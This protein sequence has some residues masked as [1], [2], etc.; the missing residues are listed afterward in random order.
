MIKS[1]ICIIGAG[2]AGNK[3]LNTLMDIDDTYVPVFCN[4]NINEMEE[5]SHFNPDTNSLYINSA[6]GTG[7]NR[8]KAKE[9][10]E[11]SGSRIISFFANKF[12][13]SSGIKTF[14]IL[15]SADGGTGSGAVPMLAQAI[16]AVN[17]EAS[18]NLV[19]AFPSLDEKELSLNNTKALWNDIVKLKRANL[20]NSIQFID[21]SKMKDE[22]QFNIDTMAELDDAISID[23]NIIDPVDAEK[24]NNCLGYKVVLKL[25]NSIKNMSDAVDYAIQNSNFLMPK[26][27]DCDYLMASFIESD[28]TKEDA[29]DLFE[30]FELDKYDY[31]D[32]NNII[33]LGGV[34]MPK[35]YIELIDM[36]LKELKKKKRQRKRDDDDLLL[37]LD[38][39]NIKEKTENKPKTKKELMNALKNTKNFFNKI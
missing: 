19:V 1:K 3:M 5:L 21:N 26:S 30:V 6:E 29:K 34:E 37:E 15:S 9:C 13:P 24:V 22:H 27:F 8:E 4:T 14:V 28:Y 33:V 16:N 23:N 32:E 17:E 11:E 10:I 12:S 7:R 38:D 35:D 18:V 39:N 25:N 20:I 31:N 2:G 36:A